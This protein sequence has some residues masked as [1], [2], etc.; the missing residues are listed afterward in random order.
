MLYL[1]DENVQA[2]SVD[3]DGRTNYLISKTEVEGAVKEL[4]TIVKVNADD[5]DDLEEDLDNVVSIWRYE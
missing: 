2:I 1:D 3:F 4:D 5:I